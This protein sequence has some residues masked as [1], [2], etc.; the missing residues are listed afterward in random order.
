MSVKRNRTIL[1]AIICST[2]PLIVACH[3]VA[4]S[5]TDGRAAIPVSN[6][7]DYEK[8]A[9]LMPVVKM[10]G[11]SVWVEYHATC[12][13]DVLEL[14]PLDLAVHSDRKNTK[15]DALV[16]VQGLLSE[17]KGVSVSELRPGI[18]GIKSDDVWSSILQSKLVDLK[19]ADI[20]RYNPDGAISAGIKASNASLQVLHARPVLK[21]GGLRE[22]PSKQRPHLNASAKYETL[23]DLLSDIA[24]TF[25]GI[26]VY[27]ECSRSDGTHIFDINF[28]R[29]DEFPSP[30]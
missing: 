24:Q 20:D 1:L 15:I 21:F 13:S 30:L 29:K 27:K 9:P 8:L 25:G 26:L 5:K 11:V 2:Y 14:I 18:I 7:S 4:P 28:Y 23:E 22:E 17:D 12:P 19:L 16:A 10:N 3:Q 6:T